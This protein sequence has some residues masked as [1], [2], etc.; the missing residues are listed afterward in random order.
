MQGWMGGQGVPQNYEKY[1]RDYDV[2]AH[3]YSFDLQ[4]YG[5]LMFPQDRVY[6]LA[7][8]SD[9]VFDIMSMLE[10]DRQALVNRIE[11]IT[12]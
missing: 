8:F 4:G 2:N 7:G 1:C 5:E 6:C 10:S 3:L 9:K 12:L 11:Q